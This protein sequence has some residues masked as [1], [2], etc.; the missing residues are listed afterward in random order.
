[1]FIFDIVQRTIDLIK[2]DAEC[3][4]WDAFDTVFA[5]P[6]I[7]ANVKQLM[8]EFHP[9]HYNLLKYWNTFRKI[10]KLGF[11]LWKVRDE[12]RSWSSSRRIKG[13][14]FYSWFTFYYINIKYIR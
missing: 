4:E 14:R 10:D 13:V 2:M 3:A 12:P 11:K 7:L 9:C 6:R 1:M 5:N 8:V